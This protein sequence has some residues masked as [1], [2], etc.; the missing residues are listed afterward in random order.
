MLGSAEVT[1]LCCR[2][3]CRLCLLEEAT[4]GG[5]KSGD[6]VRRKLAILSHEKP[7][8][9]WRPLRRKPVSQKRDCGKLEVRYNEQAWSVASDLLFS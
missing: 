9:A 2:A 4:L 8:N 5:L 7:E 1:L 6:Y 3:G